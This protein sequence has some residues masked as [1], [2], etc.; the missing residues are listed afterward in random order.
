MLVD[1]GVLDRRPYQ[2][3]PV[4]YEY[5]L[6]EMG[7]DLY[8]NTIAIHEW[9]DRWLIEKGKEPLLLRHSPCNN[10]LRSELVCSECDQA[11]APTDVSY[12]RELRQ[13]KA[14]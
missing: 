4:H 9:A 10:A 3:R 5:H 6:S 12:E 11:L 8:A 1:V 2:E 7:R 14:G 13:R